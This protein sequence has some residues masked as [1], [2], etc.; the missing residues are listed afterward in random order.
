MSIY[1]FSILSGYEMGGVDAAQA[2]RGRMLDKT[3]E[4]VNY[5]FTDAPEEYYIQ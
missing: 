5:I 2:R 3:G 4:K 1:V